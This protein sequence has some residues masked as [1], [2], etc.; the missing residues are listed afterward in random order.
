[1]SVL[2]PM[3]LILKSAVFFNKKNDLYFLQYKI[4]FFINKSI[5]KKP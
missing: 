5:D 4:C 3:L 1:M 2:L